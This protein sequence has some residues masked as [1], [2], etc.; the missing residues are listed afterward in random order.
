M[1]EY[2]IIAKTEKYGIV[3]VNGTFRVE[4]YT[5]YFGII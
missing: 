1:N 2:E 4:D 3:K 5:Q